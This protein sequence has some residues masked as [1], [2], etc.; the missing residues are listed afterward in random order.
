MLL[1]L[2]VLA[3]AAHP[4]DSFR[5]DHPASTRVEGQGGKQLVHASGFTAQ[6]KSR[7]PESAAREFIGAY[8]GAFGVTGRQTLSLIHATPQGTVGPVR[9]QR[10]IDGLPV[11][12]RDLI[13]G[14]DAQ[15][16]VFLVNGSEMGSDISGAHTLSDDAAL[17]RARS[18]MKGLE[19]VSDATVTRGWRSLG[20]SVRAAYKVEFIA[21]KPAGDWRVILD[22]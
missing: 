10:R 4:L 21:Q 3:A 1:A 16:R 9:F 11:F 19:G 20:S 5:H 7:D 8:A 17:E 18:S 22:A 12:G 14:V 13:V 6:M 15:S 2:L